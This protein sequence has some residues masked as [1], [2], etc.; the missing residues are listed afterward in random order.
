MRLV[1]TPA[2]VAAL[3]AC[4]GVLASAPAAAQ[5]TA[6]ASA[7]TSSP[8]I[9]STSGPAPQLSSADQKRVEAIQQYQHDLVNVVA[10]R[11][12]PDYLL[13]AAILAKPFKNQTQGLDFDALSQ[14]AVAVPNAAGEW[15]RLDVC[16][17]EKDCP[18]AEAFAWLKKHAADNAAIWMVALDVAARDKNDKAER[19]ALKQAATAQIY[20]DYYGKIGRAHV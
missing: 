16:K 15:A 5:L 12:D 7:A 11:A 1:V 20:D 6:P 17:S 10:L 14:R 13:G 3:L 18:N 19:A 9:A 8:A 2:V 4:G